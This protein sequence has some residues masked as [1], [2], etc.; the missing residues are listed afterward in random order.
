MKAGVVYF[1]LAIACLALLRFSSHPSISLTGG[2]RK[3]LGRRLILRAHS[4]A[5]ILRAH[6]NA[7]T[8]ARHEPVPFD[9]IVADFERKR[10]DR[11]WEREYFRQK[12]QE[13]D[14][15]TPIN[16]LNGEA[17]EDSHVDSHFEML[18]YPQATEEHASWDDD[19]GDEDYLNDED[20]FNISQ[21]LTV[22][23][24][25]IDT[26]PSDHFISLKELQDWHVRLA[27]NDALHRTKREWELHDK[28]HDNL[29]SFREYL[30]SFSEEEIAN[31]SMGHGGAGWWKEHFEVADEDGDDAL[32]QTEFHNFLHPEDSNST[33]LHQWLRQQEIRDRDDDKD[34][35]LSFLEFDQHLFDIIRDQG[36]YIGN[37][38][39]TDEGGEKRGRLSKR[40]FS[41]LDKNSD[42]YLTEDELEPIMDK[43]HP[44][45]LFY[46]KQQ[47]EYLI[48]QADDNKDGRLSLE[49]MLE[50][51][52]VFYSTAYSQ[53]DVPDYH[54][55]FR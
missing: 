38:A 2:H 46:A 42:G 37:Q 17:K 1:L 8:D 32:N 41:E 4:N 36:A 21:R 34:G 24:P 44:G 9:P 5:T 43:L 54:D 55:E 16:E 51:P 14:K 27:E 49:E 25:L 7:T 29:V 18:R 19:Y 30:P 31:A 22:L 20:Q 13:W 23:F 53:D 45:E 28:N 47:A 39:H 40:K 15:N 11:T 10:E 35:K 52:Y 48:Q 3:Q 26:N 33:K 6:S 12:Y 50:H